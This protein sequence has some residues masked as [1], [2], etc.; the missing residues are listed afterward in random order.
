MWGRTKLST[1]PRDIDKCTPGLAT[2]V[3]VALRSFVVIASWI[4][5]TG[6]DWIQRSVI[7]S[8]DSSMSNWFRASLID[9]VIMR[10]RCTPNGRAWTDENWKSARKVVWRITNRSRRWTNVLFLSDLRI[11]HDFDWRHNRIDDPIH[12]TRFCFSSGLTFSRCVSIWVSTNSDVRQCAHLELFRSME[13]VS[14]CRRRKV[15]TAAGILVPLLRK[16]DCLWN[17][18]RKHFTRHWLKLLWIRSNFLKFYRRSELYLSF[19]F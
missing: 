11:T 17:L 18:M 2:P 13:F 5:S 7:R 4:A 12:V 9:H 19:Y 8:R 3:S 6:S 16:Y 15:N 10:H 1:V 14:G